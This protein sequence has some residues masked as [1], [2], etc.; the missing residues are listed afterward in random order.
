MY[1]LQIGVLLG[2]AENSTRKQMQDIIDFETKL[3][4]ITTP[5][6]ERRD[7][8]KLYNKM[9][10]SELQRK[11][12]FVRLLTFLI[13]HSSVF[14]GI[15]YISKLELYNST[16][17]KFEYSKTFPN[18]EQFADQSDRIIDNVVILL[19][20]VMGGLLSKCHTSRK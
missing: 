13:E 20:D 2:G 1:Y 14:V 3:A 5:P 10:L 7:E 16:Q 12:P 9:P 15:S 18:F 11:A 17:R 4:K 6:E 19:L 8:E